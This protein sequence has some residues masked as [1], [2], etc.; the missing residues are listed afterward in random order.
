MKDEFAFIQSIVPKGTYQKGLRVGIGDDAAV[1]HTS[2]DYDQVICVDTMVEG[3]HFRK[4]TMEPTH[5][6]YKALAVNISDLA[7]MGAIPLYYLVSIAIPKRWSEEELQEIYQGMSELAH[8]HKVDLIG[9]DTVSTKDSL[10]ISVTVVGQVE[11][12]RRLLRKEAK[13]GDIV[14]VTG[15]VGDS[16]AGLELLLENGIS[17]D[18][19]TEQKNLVKAHQK[20]RPQVE[21]GRI[22]AKSDIRLAL[23]DVSDGVASEANEIAEESNVTIVIDSDELP[24]SKELS[25]YSLEQRMEYALF[26]GEDFQLIGAMSSSDWKSVK[27]EIETANFKITKIGEVQKGKAQVKLKHNQKLLLLEK[28]GYNHFNR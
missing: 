6:G 28:K 2:E 22:L 23:N 5:I 26:G 11:K 17:G 20:P 15:T 14:F 10:V 16:S 24:Y 19:T 18:F 7:A 4:D 25:T 12:E 13:P 27:N 9:G 1:Y 21:I 3:V 8:Q